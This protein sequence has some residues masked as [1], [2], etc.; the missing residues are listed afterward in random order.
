MIRWCFFVVLCLLTS[1][2]ADENEGFELVDYDSAK[3]NRFHAGRRWQRSNWHHR[4]NQNDRNR[5]KQNDRRW[6]KHNKP[7]RRKRR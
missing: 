6:K 5:Y 4:R 7:V 1:I 2:A 3:N